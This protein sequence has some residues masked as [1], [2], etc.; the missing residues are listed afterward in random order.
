MAQVGWPVYLWGAPSPV[1]TLEEHMWVFVLLIVGLCAALIVL[2][3][4]LSKSRRWQAGMTRLRGAW[5]MLTSAAPL[6]APPGLAYHLNGPG[7]APVP[8]PA[9]RWCLGDVAKTPCVASTT[10]PVATPEADEEPQTEKP[11]SGFTL[12]SRPGVLLSP[13]AY[14]AAPPLPPHPRLWPPTP[15]LS[16][17]ERSDRSIEFDLDI[18][19]LVD[20]QPSQVLTA[21]EAEAILDAA[22]QIADDDARVSISDVAPVGSQPTPWDKRA[23]QPQPTPRVAD[24]LHEAPTDRGRLAQPD[25][26]PNQRRAR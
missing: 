16:Q 3:L 11:Q 17:T 20:T 19:D 4:E 6:G 2:L 9:A 13:E 21:R 7:P 5:R 15:A 22:A 18:E 25:E 8:A 24:F 14:E 12:A 1:P 26:D 10:V 23:T